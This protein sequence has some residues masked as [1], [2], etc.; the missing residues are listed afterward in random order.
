MKSDI[1]LDEKDRII[2]DLLNEYPGI[3]QE[4][5]AKQI[6]VSQPSVAARIKKLRDKGFIEQIMGV[7]PHKVGLHIAKVDVATNNPNR[8]LNIYRNC[9]FF[10]NGFTVSGKN[11]LCLL[12]IGENT[13]SLES[14]VNRHLRPRKDVQNVEFNMILSSIKD[15]VTPV[16]MNVDTSDKPPCEM[17]YY[18]CKECPSY[19]DNR[20]FGCPY[21]N[22][23]KGS[24]WQSYFVK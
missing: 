9:P 14:R 11:N 20:C 23:Y 17:D 18:E 5:I 16:K 8:I 1:K 2:M 24:F 3:S 7:N 10:L 21:Q 22:E 13:S 6:N 19:N 15:F 12:F 4:E